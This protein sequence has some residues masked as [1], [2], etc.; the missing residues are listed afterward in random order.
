MH[1]WR[2]LQPGTRDS[3]SMLLPQPTAV[4]PPSRTPASPVPVSSTARCVPCT[5]QMHGR[6]NSKITLPTVLIIQ[7]AISVCFQPTEPFPRQWSC[8]SPKRRCQKILFLQQSWD[9][10][11]DEW[12]AEVTGYILIWDAEPRWCTWSCYGAE[13]SLNKSNFTFSVPHGAPDLLSCCTQYL[14][15]SK[16]LCI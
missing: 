12:E 14:T 16:L 10:L 7:Y 6:K 3:F 4:S 11:G 2:T 8:I 9:N 1:T 5:C 15:C 13:H